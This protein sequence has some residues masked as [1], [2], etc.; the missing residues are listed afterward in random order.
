MRIFVSEDKMQVFLEHDFAFTYEELMILLNENDVVFGIEKRNITD[1]IEKKCPQKRICVARGI[2]PQISKDG[3]TEWFVD[4]PSNTICENQDGAADFYNLNLFKFVS[5]GDKIAKIHLPENGNTGIDVFGRSINAIPGKNVDLKIRNGFKKI[6]GEIFA[7]GDGVINLNGNSLSLE[8]VLVVN[9]DVDYRTG[10]IKSNVN[11]IVNGWLK[12]GFNIQSD[13]NVLING[14]IEGKNRLDING[15]LSVKL[16]ITGKNNIDIECGGSVFAKFISGARMKC[17]G[18][19]YINEY[20]M[21]SN[22]CC[23]GSIYLNGIKGA[24]IT[25]CVSAGISVVVKN[26]RGNA[27]SA[28]FVSGFNR[29][30]YIVKMADLLE[31]RSNLKENMKKLAWNIRGTERSRKED[32]SGLVS[33]YQELE[34]ELAVVESGIKNIKNILGKVEG[35]GMIKFLSPVE[36]VRLKIKDESLNLK[37]T[38]PVKLYYDPGERGVITE[39]L[40]RSV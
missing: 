24:L 15:D 4:I 35:E 12:S 33:D 37:N 5:K 23:D 10:N 8:P 19:V 6:G 14:G 2:P 38:S 17:G 32:I 7:I 31:E 28:I 22:V 26:F 30:S 18:D 9:S 21:N 36:E 25:S 39:C 16:G 29:N 27:E 40:T 1:Y 13:K 34:E 11:V 3:F 20:V